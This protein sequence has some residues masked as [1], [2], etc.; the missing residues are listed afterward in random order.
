[1]PPQRQAYFD[2]KTWEAQSNLG[3]EDYYKRLRETFGRI[4]QRY[5]SGGQAVG[6]SL[7]GGLDSRMIVAAAARKAVGMPCYTFGGMLRD[8]EDVKISRVIARICQLKHQVIPVDAE[9]FEQFG[10]LACES[11][12]F[13]DGAMDVTGAVELLVNRKAR[14]IAPVRLT[15]N[16]GS[17]I[18]RFNVAFKPNAIAESMLA[19]D[20]VPVYRQAAQTYNQERQCPRATFIAFKQVPWH[21]HARW[22]VEQSQITVRSPYIDNDLTP[23]AYQAPAEP[24]V[25]KAMALRLIAEFLPALADVPTDRGREKRPFIIPPALWR[26]LQEFLPR[27]EYAYDY[28]MPQWLAAVDHVVRP[29]HFERLFLGRQKFA[30]F[31]MWY[32]NQLSGYVKDVLLDARSLSRPYLDAKEV[33]RAVEAHTSGKGNYTLEI[34]KLLSLELLHRQLIDVD[35]A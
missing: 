21:Q 12:W 9:L 7:T 30:H 26:N 2:P 22:A 28:G 18:L 4:V 16:Y 20:F 1:M 19:P 15:G 6:L 3:A 24:A 5:F 25:N 17:E 29:F 32:A 23:L 27:A 10:R 11:V 34:H 14:E 13:S 31:R 33:R 8:C 35:G